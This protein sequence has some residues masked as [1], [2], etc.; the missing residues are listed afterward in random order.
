MKNFIIYNAE[1][2]ILRTGTCLDG[3]FQYQYGVDEY[4]LNGV[5]DL[6]TQYIQDGVVVNMPE[7][8]EGEY[9]FDYAT[10]LWVFDSNT[11]IAK[12]LKTRDR[13]LADGPDRI[14]PLWWNSM[15]EVQ[16][17]EWTNYRQALLDIT[18]QPTYPELIV[19]PVKP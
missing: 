17:Q 6:K 3:D 16:Q 14:S 18:S 13:L 15:T 12:A 19:W 7:K 4:I 2:K 11:A 10:K 9:V 1:G 8:P 5:A